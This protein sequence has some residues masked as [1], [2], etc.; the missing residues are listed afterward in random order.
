MLKLIL[1]TYWFV[2]KK[3]NFCCFIQISLF[4]ELIPKTKKIVF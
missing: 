3:M 1:K 4:L 2:D